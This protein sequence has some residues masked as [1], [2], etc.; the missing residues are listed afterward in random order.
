MSDFVLKDF[1][2]I[3]VLNGSVANIPLDIDKGY[4]RTSDVIVTIK[5]F[6]G[7]KHEWLRTFSVGHD[8]KDGYWA[9]GRGSMITSGPSKKDI[10]FGYEL[11]GMI[12]IED[13]E[14]R[15]E[16]AP[17]HNIKFVEMEGA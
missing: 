1:P 9:Y 3:L 12:K 5:G 11:G 4:C 6:P 14:F 8:E 7:D 17:N 15:I 10:G 2:A 16:A 13:K